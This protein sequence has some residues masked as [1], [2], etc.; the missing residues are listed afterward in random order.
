MKNKVWH[1]CG[2]YYSSDGEQKI[3]MDYITGVCETIYDA[4]KQA[5]EH[6]IRDISR[7]FVSGIIKKENEI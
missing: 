7:V 4:I 1:V 6:G 2:N 3:A 5:E